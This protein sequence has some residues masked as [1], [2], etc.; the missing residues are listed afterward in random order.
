MNW[1]QFLIGTIQTCT[2]ATKSVSVNL[3]SIPHRYDPNLKTSF[4]TQID[5][6]F[7]FLIGTIQTGRF[8]TREAA[9]RE[10]FQF[11]I[12]TIQTRKGIGIG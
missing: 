3:V 4:L 5:F 12:G 10:L 1:F 2:L 9:E 6:M 11:L 8:P 7:Q